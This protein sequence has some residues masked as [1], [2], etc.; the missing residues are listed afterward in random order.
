M[1]RILKRP[2]E[3]V[4]AH[5]GPAHL[6]RAW[7]RGDVLVLAYHGI[8]P[9]DVPES[10]E[11]SLHLPRSAFAEQLDRLMESH[12]IVPLD[13]VLR[14]DHDSPGRPRAV[15]TFDDAYQ[16]A[17]RLGLAETSRRGLPATVFVAPRYIG[18][19]SFW[20][21]ALAGGLGGEI[22]EALRTELLD[23][24]RG[25][26]D[27]IRAWAVREGWPVREP[28]DHARAATLEEL[29]EAARL[30]GV[31][32]GSHSWSHRNL[33]RLIGVELR[34]ELE[35]PLR[36]LRERFENVI[37]WLSYPYGCVSPR[38]ER[39]AAEVGYRGAVTVTA[40]WSTVPPRR[41]LAV[42]RLNVPA[43]ISQSGFT[44]QTAGLFRRV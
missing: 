20:W 27:T 7:Y 12:E 19:A 36:W 15:I 43:G 24:L 23:T 44:L 40:G 5:G 26:D 33:T 10:G 41:P 1:M 22:P 18:G 2:A 8:C 42:P 21:D 30:P 38:V 13:E 25:S 37:P 39:A 16:G 35:R 34:D 3:Y 28:P 11:R 29:Q 4:L 14:G 31:T 17:V 9:D 6:L 32:L